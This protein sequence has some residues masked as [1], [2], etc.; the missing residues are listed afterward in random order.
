MPNDL[1]MELSAVTSVPVL[2]WY[3]TRTI[4]DTVLD[5]RRRSIRHSGETF[6]IRLLGTFLNVITV[7]WNRAL[8][9]PSWSLTETMVARTVGRMAVALLLFGPCVELLMAL[10]NR[11]TL[12]VSLD[13]RIGVLLVTLAT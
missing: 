13:G 7:A 8:V 2:T 5:L 1:L 6:L 4:V 11:G 10:L 3:A 12:V 9:L